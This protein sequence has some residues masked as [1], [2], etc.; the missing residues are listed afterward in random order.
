MISRFRVS[1]RPILSIIPTGD[2]TSSVKKICGSDAK[3]EKERNEITH[4][5][6]DNK[7]KQ[8]T[9]IFAKINNIS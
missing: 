5:V 7:S 8:G 2:C 6:R 9:Q 3:G 4:D 1:R